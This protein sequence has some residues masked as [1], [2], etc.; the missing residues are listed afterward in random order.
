MDRT[1]DMLWNDSDKDGKGKSVKKIKA[2]TV[3]LET[4][5]LIGKGRQNPTCAQ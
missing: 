1:D 2:L 5:I 3:K 4:V